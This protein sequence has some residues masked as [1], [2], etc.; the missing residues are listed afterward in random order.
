MG[1]NYPEDNYPGVQLS[2]RELPWGQLSRGHLS[3]GQLSSGQLSGGN[4]PV[5]NQN[6]FV[7]KKKCFYYTTF[8]HP[9]K[10]IFLNMNF[11]FDTFL[12]AI[13][14]LPFLFAKVRILLSVCL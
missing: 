10:I 3:G 1:S 13:S 12:V 6:K 7:F 4:C 11:S 14:D 8:L 2:G 9:I 5:P